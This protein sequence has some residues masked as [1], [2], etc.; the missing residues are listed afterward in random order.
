MRVKRRH[1]MKTR[2]T[3][4]GHL[5]APF[6]RCA[7]ATVLCRNCRPLL[8]PKRS[9]RAIGEGADDTPTGEANVPPSVPVA[10]KLTPRDHDRLRIHAARVSRELRRLVPLAE[11]VRDLI[12]DE[13]DRSERAATEAVFA[14][15]A[16]L[17]KDAKAVVS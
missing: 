6:E 17:A 9:V 10:A 2:C 4:C 1:M 14:K 12:L 15:A 8:P 3:N 5:L 13:L 16:V 11:I 7:A